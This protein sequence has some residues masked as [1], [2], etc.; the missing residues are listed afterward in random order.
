MGFRPIPH[1]G[2]RPL[3]PALHHRIRGDAGNWENYLST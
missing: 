3:D 1:K 2:A